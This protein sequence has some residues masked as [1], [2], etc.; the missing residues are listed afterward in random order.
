MSSVK[1]LISGLH[2]FLVLNGMLKT[3]QMMSWMWFCLIGMEKVVF[4]DY[5]EAYFE[6]F[7]EMIN[8]YDDGF[9]SLHKFYENT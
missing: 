7:N 3:I 2:S 4:E 1:G 8:L 9:P 6:E 5:Y